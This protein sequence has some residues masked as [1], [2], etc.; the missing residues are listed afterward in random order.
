M[1]K[2][3][4][5]ILILIAYIALVMV[6]MAIFT[7]INLQITGRPTGGIT[8]LGIISFWTSYK[9]CQWIKSNYLQQ[10]LQ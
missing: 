1:K 10:H 4:S 9:V 8:A 6:Q 5:Y 7:F 2:L 3:L